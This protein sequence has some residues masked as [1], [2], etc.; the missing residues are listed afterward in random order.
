MTTF[1]TTVANS[2]SN[3][4]SVAAPSDLALPMAQAQRVNMSEYGYEQSGGHRGDAT[5]LANLFRMI[6]NG[7]IIDENA[8]VE[9]QQKNHLAIREQIVELEKQAEDIVADQKKVR[10]VDIPRTKAEILDYDEQILQVRKDEALGLYQAG[11]INRFV[12]WKL[13]IG[14]ILGAVYIFSFYVSAVYSGVIRNIGAELEGADIEIQ[15]LFSSVFVPQ[16]F[17][18]FDFHWV[19]PILLFLFAFVLDFLVGTLQKTARVASVTVAVLITLFLDALIA[20]KIEEKIHEVKLMTGFADNEHHWWLSADFYIVIMMGFIGTIAW[21]VLI[22][23][24]KKEIEKKDAN[25]VVALQIRHLKDLKRKAERLV[26]EFEG[27]FTD[28][29]AKMEKLLLDI[30]QLKSRQNTLVLSKAELEKSVN[31]FYNG[32]LSYINGLG[33]GA[34]LKYECQAV[35]QQF[36]EEN[37]KE[38]PAPVEV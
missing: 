10:E 31:D 18:V 5:A 35:M 23:A 32:W 8:N 13:I 24:L 11:A 25:R 36:Y 17:T 28:L 37:I 27:H 15:T 3:N 30:K 22:H 29:G 16:A 6:L 20:Y 9:Q 26:Y 2:L 14:V 7:R 38:H 12:Y 33:N 19:A 34:A 21:G 4:H 1:F